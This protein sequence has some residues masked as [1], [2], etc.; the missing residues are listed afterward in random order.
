MNSKKSFYNVFFG[1]LSQAV[2]IALGVVIPRLVLVHLGSE[3]N[4][5]M[6]SVNQVLT[7]LGLL[8]AGIGTATMQALYRPVAE[9]NR[10]GINRIMSATNI[11]YRRVGKWYFSAVSAVSIVFPFFV[12]SELSPYLIMLVLFISGMS[13]VV[14]FFFQ[15]K[16]RILMMAEGKNYILINLATVI[17]VLSSLTKIALLVGGFDILAL[18]LMNFGYNIVQMLYITIYIKRNYKWLDLSSEP[19]YDAVSQKNS[20]LVHQVADLIFRNT[21]VILLTFVCGFKT[22]SIYSM[23]V[24]LFDMVR[25]AVTAVNSSVNF[26]MGQTYQT[27][28]KR[29]EKMFSAFET[30][31]MTLTFSL[32]CVAGIFILPFLRLYTAG[33]SDINYIDSFLPYLFI[34]TYLLS[35]GRY[36]A[37]KV[38]EYAGHFKLTQ[39][40]AVLEAAINLT[41]SV[42]CVF[43]FGIY[44]VLFGTIAGLLYRTVDMILY[45]SKRLLKRSPMKMFF[46]WFVNAA[47]FAGATFLANRALSC[48]SLD[49]YFNIIAAAACCCAVIIPLFFAVDSAIDPKSFIF[50]RDFMLG[51]LKAFAAKKFSRS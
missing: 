11:Y 51:K 14:G 50:C 9:E 47:L 27:D 12:K 41:V 5:L 4:G 8:E 28:K 7:C 43:K 29:F 21:D 48:F 42:I 31:N 32:Y 35:N 17:G 37:F 19:D 38:I 3:S 20:V 33:V 23:Y 44:G 16:F 22:V 24:M 26:V 6:S 40:R 49:S 18:Q 10:M 39:S 45:S 36:A 1:L 25:T 34:G 2:S 46:K 13:N 30:Y 15:G